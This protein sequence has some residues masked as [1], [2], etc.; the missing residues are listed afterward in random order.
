MHNLEH[1]KAT[2]LNATTFVETYDKCVFDDRPCE[3]NDDT[4]VLVR[5]TLEIS[6]KHVYMLRKINFHKY[7]PLKQ[8][9]TRHCMTS[10]NT[11]DQKMT[12]AI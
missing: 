5:E 1:N 3:D 12:H 9:K 10:H 11:H 4:C 8:T 7:C 6:M 2:S